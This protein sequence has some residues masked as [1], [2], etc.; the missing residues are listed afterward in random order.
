M[1]L[2]MV[3]YTEDNGLT[4]DTILLNAQDYSDAYLCTSYKIKKDAIILSLFEII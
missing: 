3:T 4:K 2:Y 1:K